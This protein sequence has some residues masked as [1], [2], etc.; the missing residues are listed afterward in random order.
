VPIEQRG[1]SRRPDDC[2]HIKPLRHRMPPP[3][4]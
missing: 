4:P 3:K 2:A 1:D